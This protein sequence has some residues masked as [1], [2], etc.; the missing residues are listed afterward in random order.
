MT[1][2]EQGF[3]ALKHAHNLVERMKRE[4]GRRDAPILSVRL[5]ESIARDKTLNKS[6]HQQAACPRDVSASVVAK[7][8]KYLIGDGFIVEHFPDYAVGKSIYYDITDDGRAYLAE[9]M[10]LMPAVVASPDY[11]ALTEKT[12][13]KEMKFYDR[14]PSI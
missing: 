9:I 1:P 5:L 12:K 7:A 2:A 13:K 10:K 11:I 6:Q 8:F 14:R 4:I 3:A